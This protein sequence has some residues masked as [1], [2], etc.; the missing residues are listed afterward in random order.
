[1]KTG[2]ASYKKNDKKNNSGNNNNSNNMNFQND[3]SN[4]QNMQ[5]DPNF[6]LNQ[7]YM[8]QFCLANGYQAPNN[9]NMALQ[10]AQLNQLMNQNMQQPN[11]FQNQTGNENNNMQIPGQDMNILNN[12]AMLQMMNNGGFGDMNTMMNNGDNNQDSQ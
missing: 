2:N 12:L 6:L 9:L 11:I 1:M 10:L 7:Q 5:N 3:L 8:L 4:L